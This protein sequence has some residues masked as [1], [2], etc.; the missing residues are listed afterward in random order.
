MTTDLV[1]TMTPEEVE[2]LDRKAELERLSAILAQ[3]ELDREDLRLSVTRFEQRYFAE[4]GLR[5]VALDDLRAQIAEQRAQRTPQDPQSQAQARVAREEANQSAQEYHHSHHAPEL[6]QETDAPSE[7]TKALYKKIAIK[8]HPDKGTD[9]RSKQ[10]RGKL[11]AELNVAYE[12]NDVPR[13]KQILDEW[14]KSPETVPGDG[15]VPELVRTIRAIAQVKRRIAEIE[16][17]MSEIVG[18]EIH[19]LMVTV[20]EADSAGRNILHEM[21]KSVDAEILQ[22]QDALKALRR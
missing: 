14:E 12:R 7:E 11:T 18:S 10:I 21:A 6:P 2:L 1:A 19:Q 22:A 4:L 16:K 5:Y 17:E 3:K 15:T 8:I 20:R 9:E 13:M